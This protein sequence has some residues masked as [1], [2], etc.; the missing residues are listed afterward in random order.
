MLNAKRL[1]ALFARKD[2]SR[3]PTKPPQVGDAVWFA[4]KQCWMVVRHVKKGPKPGLEEYTL[5]G[6]PAVKRPNGKIVERYTTSAPAEFLH[7]DMGAQ[8]WT[9]GQG[10]NP[11][12]PKPGEQIITPAPVVMGAKTGSAPGRIL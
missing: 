9:M 12:K 10:P 2:T 3:V 4:S 8:I 11:R 7:W 6:G 5:T 1:L